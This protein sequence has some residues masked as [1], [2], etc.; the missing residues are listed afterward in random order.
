MA[1][2]SVLWRESRLDRV[3]KC[4]R[5]THGGDGG[6]VHA[7]LNADV[8]H[9]SGLQSCGSVWACPCC[10]AKI[11]NGRAIEISSAAGRW[12]VA[13]N[14]VVMA[15]FTAPHDYGMRLSALMP[16]IAGGFRSVIR[17]RPWRRLR[18]DLGIAGTIRAVE[19]TYGSNGWHPHL[20]VLVF[21]RGDLGAEGIARLAVYLRGRWA[22]WITGQGYRIPHATHGVDLQVCTS[23]REAG[24]YMAKTQDGR[25][26]GN[27]MA[28]GDMKSGRKG[29]RTPLEILD[30]FRWTG[31][32]EDL[33]LWHEYETA[34][35]GHK[36]ITWSKGL[37]D[38]IGGLDDEQSD[39]ELAAVEVGGED[40]AIIP[41]EVWAR[42]V[43]IPGL[44]GA[45]LDAAERSGLAGM[46]K[47]LGRHGLGPALPPGAG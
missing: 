30:D 11:R 32:A 46:N 6:N 39:D 38:I 35:K 24:L 18:D 36:A 4:G 12:H 31:D 13:G 28:R 27:E 8:A 40:I 5:V 47:L 33:G 15:T 9:F 29:S 21:A 17:G 44:D 2:R 19:V 10:Q 16:V 14:A 41:A 23:A 43:A 34:T 7:R 25:S 45:L 1:Q 37:R 22:A 42:V 20:H 26:P 3:R